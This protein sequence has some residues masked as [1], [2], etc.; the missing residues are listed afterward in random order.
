MI[1]FRKEFNKGKIRKW[2]FQNK[3]HIKLQIKYKMLIIKYLNFNYKIIK[4]KLQINL[5]IKNDYIFIIKQ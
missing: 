1:N 4:K 3:N 5:K 2:Q